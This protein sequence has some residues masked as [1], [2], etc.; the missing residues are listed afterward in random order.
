MGS[1]P[2]ERSL[3][4]VHC[5]VNTAGVPWANVQALR[6]RDID[7]QLVVFNRYQLHSE[8]DWSLERHGRFA[9]RQL[10]Q[11]SA[12]ARLLPRTDVFHFYFGLTLVPQSLQFPDPPS[13]AQEVG[14]ALPR[15]GH[16]G[17]VARAARVREE[18]R[19]GGRGLVRRC[20]LGAGGR[21]DPAG[22]R[23]EGDRARAA[24]RS[25]SARDPARTLLAAPQGDGAR[26]RRVRRARR[27]ARS[28]RGPAPRR[29]VRALP[30]RRHRRR[31]AQRRAGTASSRSSAWRSGSRS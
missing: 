18:G 21:D 3:R 7:A 16:P 10:T 20:P 27:G 17:E 29:G 28:R 25:R 31:P 23:R 5:P 14:D 2:T 8:A 12:L 11:W 6:R 24:V 19:R 4:V 30:R 26:R 9:R 1:D 13:S 22:D 15:F